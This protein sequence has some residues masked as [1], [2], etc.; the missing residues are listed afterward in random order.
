M[1]KGLLH[2]LF[3]KGEYIVPLFLCVWLIGSPPLLGRQ[4]EQVVWNNLYSLDLQHPLPA[5]AQHLPANTLH[6]LTTYGLVK[7]LLY[8][9]K[10]EPTAIDNYLSFCEV[11]IESLERLPAYDPRQYHY[12]AEVYLSRALVHIRSGN[13][14]KGGWQVRKAV[15]LLSDISEGYPDYYD[16]LP[17]YGLLQGTLE[18]VPEE[19]QWT[20][21]TLGI[22]V[23]EENGRA[24]IKKGISK[25]SGVQKTKGQYLLALGDMYLFENPALSTQQLEELTENKPQHQLAHHLLTMLYLKDFK[26]E[27]ALSHL[28]YL[29]KDSLLLTTLP[30]I[31]YM[32]GEALLRKGEY[33]TAIESFGSFLRLNKGDHLVKDAYFKQGIAWYI[34]G[35]NEKMKAA[36]KRAV[37]EGE[38]ETGTDR[39]ALKISGGEEP[40]PIPA[41]YEARLRMDGGYLNEAEAVLNRLNR[42]QRNQ[43]SHDERVEWLYRTARVAHLNRDTTSAITYYYH[44]IEAQKKDHYFAPNACLQLGYLLKEKDPGASRYYLKKAID[45][46]G[47]P[48][49]ASIE[50]KAKAALKELP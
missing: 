43:L 26:A 13:T 19:Y 30:S 10:D 29:D 39:Y 48:Y 22:T 38:A 27:K 14:L 49:E 44:T 25:A 33:H 28:A 50:Q 24:I 4:S 1:I 32:K 2:T 5:N 40:L 23:E 6:A 7:T 34:L 36:F 18:A 16:H 20:L 35:N 46:Q 8:Q 42:T 12:T 11:A 37:K 21:P 47:H 3:K 31:S 9:G 17:L 45:Y 15:R 41:L